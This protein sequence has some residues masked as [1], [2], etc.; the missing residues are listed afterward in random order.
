ML[1]N[2]KDIFGIALIGSSILDSVKYSIQANK[3]RKEKSAKTMSRKFIN[4]AIL[5]DIVKLG[6]GITIVD[7]IIIISS[8]MSLVCMLHLW[9]NIYIFYP[10]KHYPAKK[11]VELK[12]PN[13]FFYF[14]NSLLPNS[15]RK[16]L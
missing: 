6:Y 9:W 3:I 14:W 2:I 15:R 13:I 5:N 8:I 4:F 16:H 12:R 10:Y 1:N 7:W 11:T